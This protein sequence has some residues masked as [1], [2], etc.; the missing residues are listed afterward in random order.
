MCDVGRKVGE[1]AIAWAMDPALLQVVRTVRPFRGMGWH[2]LARRANLV[3][4]DRL[5]RMITT[6][7]DRDRKTMRMTFQTI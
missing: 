7:Y 3:L 2:N 5:I 1:S 6:E 4:D